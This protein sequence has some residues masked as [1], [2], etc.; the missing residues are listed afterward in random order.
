MR[1]L[2]RITR[3][4]PHLPGRP[5]LAALMLCLGG[6]DAA[7]ANNIAVLMSGQGAVYSEVLDSLQA[8]L[9]KTTTSVRTTV[10][11][12]DA[13]GREPA[14]APLLPSDTQL[15]VTV[16]ANAARAALNSPEI[17]VPILCVLLPKST[18]DSLQAAAR[19]SVPGRRVSAIYLDQP[20]SRQVDLIRQALPGSAR[21]GVVVGPE[22][23]RDAERLQSLAE[24][25]SLS[26]VTER[27]SRDTELY[28]ALQRALGS[29]DVLLALPDPYIIN[30]ETAQ[31]L[32]ITSFRLRVPVIG[33]SAAYVRAGAL[34]AVFSSPAQ[35]GAEA[36]D[37]A[38]QVVRGQ[39]LPAPRH[40]RNFSVAVNRQVARSLDLAVEDETVL[41]DRLMRMERE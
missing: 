11:A 9:K 39:G 32:L 40:P 24:L 23:A 28:P 30:A 33:F 1:A 8:E 31:N 15:L 29:A 26:L 6:I 18:Y 19:Q 17:K 3:L 35:V 27:A 25:R 16:G 10:G 7:W 34:A 4:T 2:R 14:L 38:R 13:Q 20:L 41:R 36:G 5:M 37:V 21:I 12:L 22:S